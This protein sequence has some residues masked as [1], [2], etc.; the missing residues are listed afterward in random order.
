[1]KILTT[2]LLGMLTLTD[3]TNGWLRRWNIMVNPDKS[4]HCTFALRR[5][6]CP[7]VTLDGS[8]IPDSN[9]AKYLGIIMDRR[10]TWKPHLTNKRAQ[11]SRR[12]KKFL[13]LMGK[14]STLRLRVKLQIYKAIMKPM[15]TYGIS[16]WGTANYTNLREIQKFQ[17]KALRVLSNANLLTSNAEIHNELGVIQLRQCTS[18][19]PATAAAVRPSSLPPKPDQL[20]T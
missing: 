14:K 10:L 20:Q 12:V 7:P 9:T 15:W 5:G 17:N 18:R 19:C 2:Q 3:L 4:S 16:I 1:M 11:M 6:D 13:W 8:S